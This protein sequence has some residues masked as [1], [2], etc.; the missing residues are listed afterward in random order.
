MGGA[1]TSTARADAA[2][3][4]RPRLA[5]R[6]R[7]LVGL[8]SGYRTRFRSP[9]SRT[10]RRKW[11]VLG[12]PPWFSRPAPNPDSPGARTSASAALFWPRLVSLR[13]VL[14]LAKAPVRSE[15]RGTRASTRC[16]Q[17]STR[18]PLW[19]FPET[20]VEGP[21]RPAQAARRRDAQD[22]IR[23]IAVRMEP[24]STT[25]ARRAKA[26]ASRFAADHARPGGALPSGRDCR[27][28]AHRLSWDLTVGP[29]RRTS[30]SRSARLVR[31]ENHFRSSAPWHR[32]P[33]T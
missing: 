31:I 30:R 11:L 23:A 24:C 22:T 26:H 29:G 15:P 5:L 4:I 13:R 20:S 33:R 9:E 1:A 10:E 28:E 3:K 14:L 6:E 32:L 12:C 2:G 19:A 25:R 8:D 27:A 16:R 17:G 21:S 7:T 18:E